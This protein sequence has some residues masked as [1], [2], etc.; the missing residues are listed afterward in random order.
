MCPKPTTDLRCAVRFSSRADE[1]LR[2]DLCM[3]ITIEKAVCGPDWLVMLNYYPLTFRSMAEAQ[4]FVDRLK[5]RIEAPH[6]IPVW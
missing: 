5:A 1:R 2:G 4:S 6:I 3:V